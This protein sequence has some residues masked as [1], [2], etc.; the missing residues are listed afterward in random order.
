L[1][2][3]DHAVAERAIELCLVSAD[4]AVGVLSLSE[5]AQEHM[6]A[7]Y[8]DDHSGL[9]ICFDEAHAFF[10]VDG[11][12]MLYSNEPILVS[13]NSGWV[14]LAG[15]RWA[16]EDVLEGRAGEI[17]I[18][19][20]FRK[21]TGWQQEH[22]WRVIRPLA[23]AKRT[24]GTDK[25]GYL[26]YLFEVPPS[27]VHSVIFGHRAGDAAVQ[28]TLQLIEHKDQWKHVGVFRR[29]RVATGRIEED[30]LR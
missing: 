7:Y 17:P 22:E 2:E 6:W 11:G 28:S 18:G 12:P 4:V 16:N 5:S 20:F 13:T 25:N 9:A 19:L 21:R 29:K 23:G 14:R 10:A 26:V 8:A 27:A 1:D 24:T 3:L 15:V 30:R